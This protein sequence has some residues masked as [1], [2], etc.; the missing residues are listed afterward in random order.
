MFFVCT[1]FSL[2]SC[3]MNEVDITLVEQKIHSRLDTM[4]SSY[5]SVISF[6]EFEK[7]NEIIE[8]RSYCY[9]KFCLTFNLTPKGYNAYEVYTLKS[10]TVDSN[11][12]GFVSQAGE[13]SNEIEFLIWLPYLTSESSHIV[14]QF[15]FSKFDSTIG[16]NVEKTVE[17]N[18]QFNSLTAPNWINR[19]ARNTKIEATATELNRNIVSFYVDTEVEYDYLIY[20]ID[21]NM[22]SSSRYEAVESEKLM[23]KANS[24]SY[25]PEYNNAYDWYLSL[26]IVGFQVN[27]IS[28]YFGSIEFSLMEWN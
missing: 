9:V 21:R 14:N 4:H 8:S 3:N 15:T 27:N 18:Y 6:E 12:A 23:K 1:T 19:F 13:N 20:N 10:L 16:E 17:L 2:Y 26:S 5:N 25:S 24:Y 11:E 28:Y 22:R 7:D